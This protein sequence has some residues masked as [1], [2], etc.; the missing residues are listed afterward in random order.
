LARL[1]AK[2]I[3]GTKIITNQVN[4]G[5]C[6]IAEGWLEN[7]SETPLNQISADVKRILESS[8]NPKLGCWE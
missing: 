8:P 4:A 5:L 3:A 1:K 7:I 6:A 2:T